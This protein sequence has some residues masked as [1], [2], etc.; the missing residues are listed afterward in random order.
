MA[1][2]L[3]D[4]ELMERFFNVAKEIQLRCD[5]R[6]AIDC[7]SGNCPFSKDK[8]CIFGWQKD[9]NYPF[10]WKIDDEEE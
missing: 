2:K 8:H 10:D 9:F 5:E 7:D 1:I 6:N 3:S 4:D